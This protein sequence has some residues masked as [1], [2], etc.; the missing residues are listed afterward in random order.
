MLDFL[1]VAGAE[2]AGTTSIHTY[3]SAHPQVCPSI[4]KETD[5]FRN[6]TVSFDGYIEQFQSPGPQHRIY[7]ESSPG[8]LA[9]ARTAAPRIHAIVPQAKLVFFLR[10]PIERL[11]SSYTF[12]ISRLHIP[13]TM[14]FEQFVDHCFKYSENEK[15]AEEIG[16]LPW[17]LL[18]LRR[19]CY[20]DLLAEFSRLNGSDQLL[21]I[22]YDRLRGS[23]K[24]VMRDICNFSGIDAGFFDDYE[25]SRENVTF[26]G[27]NRGLHS[28]A[29][30]ANNSLETFWR[31][32]PRLKAG[33]RSA[34]RK[35]NGQNVEKSPISPATESRLARYYQNDIGAL[36]E[37]VPTLE[38]ARWP[39]RYRSA[40]N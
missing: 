11:Y 6:Q 23:L 38:T 30:R 10:D 3:L 2:K 37:T 26:F 20:G 21:I 34:Y 7:L 15:Y 18:A 24:D 5:Y 29:I 4:K 39:S 40:A 36:L 25:F 32:N 22:D 33:L 16:L 27:K 12:Y 19:S 17:H 31:A 35:F 14:S 8:Y 1:I 13:P 28:L 9:E